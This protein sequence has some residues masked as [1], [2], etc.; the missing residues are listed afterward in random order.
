MDANSTMKYL[1]TGAQNDEVFADEPS[2]PVT[3]HT[4]HLHFS[5]FLRIA[6]NF[7]FLREASGHQVIARRD[8]FCYPLDF[9]C[10]PGCAVTWEAIAAK[11]RS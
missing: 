11:A 7:R 10:S 2:D 9:L 6:R 3:L 4:V 5:D 8:S 1:K